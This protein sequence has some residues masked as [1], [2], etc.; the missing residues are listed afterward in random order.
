MLPNRLTRPNSVTSKAKKQPVNAHADSAIA[1][2]MAATRGR[3]TASAGS[4]GLVACSISFAP[5][6]SRRLQQPHIQIL[7]VARARH[8][9]FLQSRQ[10]FLDTLDLQAESGEPGG[11]LVGAKLQ[12]ETRCIALRVQ[13]LLL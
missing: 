8:H 2:R 4:G 1:I 11:A 12:A 6:E 5:V 7:D 13:D 3:R 9:E 10:C